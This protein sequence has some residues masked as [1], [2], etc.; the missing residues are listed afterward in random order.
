[1]FTWNCL[2]YL[3]IF[4]VT[5]KYIYVCIVFC[6]VMFMYLQ[7]GIDK[8]WNGGKWGGGGGFPLWFWLVFAHWS[9]NIEIRNFNQMR[10]GAGPNPLNLPLCLGQN[11]SM[12][13][14]CHMFILFC[15]CFCFCFC[16]F[17]LGGGVQLLTVLALEATIVV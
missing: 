14:Y 2:H 3:F 17:F 13:V 7:N 12:C 4:F 9:P 11:E 15:F 16:F 6:Y 5:C 8:L 10:G 1:M